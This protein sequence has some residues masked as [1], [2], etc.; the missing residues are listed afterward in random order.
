MVFNFIHSRSFHVIEFFLLALDDD[1]GEEYFRAAREVARLYHEK[2]QVEEA[3]L[4]IEEAVRKHPTSV[5]PGDINL[6]LELILLLPNYEDALEVICEH[7]SAHFTSKKDSVPSS[8]LQDMPASKQLQTFQSVHV[9]PDTALEIVAKLC[10]VLIHLSANHLLEG[11]EVQLLFEDADEF[12]DLFLD[13]AEAYMTMKCFAEPLPYLE[14]LVNSQSYSKA[15][16]W[17]KYGECLLETG[18]VEE[19]ETAYQNVV[20]M[21]PQHMEAR[22]TLSN[23]LNRLGRP[24]EALRTLSQDEEAELLNP[25]L[26]FEKCQ[27]LQ[28]EGRLDEFVPKAELLFSR[29]FVQ[30]RNKYVFQKWST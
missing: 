16:V 22:R 7:C 3:K 28:T 21:A 19:A 30:I 15:A 10:I 13:I 12:G 5:E 2:S 26:L 11:L 18:K 4:V 1:Q 23:I 14:K 27:L 9:H 6:L 24:D 29:H 20:R 8:D 17:L 25:T